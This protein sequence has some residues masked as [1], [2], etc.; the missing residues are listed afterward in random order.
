MSRGKKV[1]GG[2]YLYPPAGFSLRKKSAGNSNQAAKFAACAV[3]TKG[4]RSKAERN[5]QISA[6]LR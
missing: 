3:K 5:A 6:C 1:F 4:V 2:L